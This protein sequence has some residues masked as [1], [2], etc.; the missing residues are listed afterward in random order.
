M[1]PKYLLILFIVYLMLISISCDKKTKKDLATFTEWKIGVLP[2][3]SKD[4]LIEI[5]QPLIKYLARET[6]LNSKLVLPPTYSALLDSFSNGSAN[7]ALFGGVT[8]IEARLKYGAQ[9]IAFRNVD[10]NFSSVILT[11]STN[12]ASS[13][14]DLKGTLFG[15]GSNLSTSGYYMPIYFFRE[16]GIIPK[17]FFKKVIHL[18]N[19]EA[20]ALWV[21]NGEIFAG[22]LNSKI[23]QKMF[24][25]GEL[26][27]DKVKVIWQSPTFADYVWASNSTVSSVFKEK[28]LKA[29]LNLN[30]QNPDHKNILEKLGADYFLLASNENFSELQEIYIYLN[31]F[32]KE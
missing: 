12:D 15:F 5:Y 26:D 21:Q 24:T 18:K 9:P 13:I 3:Q 20:T 11:Q 29:L 7:I 2:D 8:F 23:A 19:H 4:H 17:T 14:N 22:V 16:M 25:S 30:A 32:N 6:G 10:L 31:S 1:V 28:F 27:R